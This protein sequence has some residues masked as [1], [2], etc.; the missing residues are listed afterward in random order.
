MRR[1]LSIRGLALLLAI[2][3]FAG[4]TAWAASPKDEKPPATGP[5]EVTYYF[6]P[7]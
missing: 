6:L 4:A 7:G 3:A 2:L 5:L 1:L